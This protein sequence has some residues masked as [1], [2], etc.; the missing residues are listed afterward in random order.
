MA[1]QGPGE[2]VLRL[3]GSVDDVTSPSFMDDADRLFAAGSITRFV[4]DFSQTE[5]LDS[6]GL[7]LLVAI[8]T[9]A[10]SNGAVVELRAMP[11][12]VRKLVRRAGLER[13]FDIAG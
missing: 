11:D 8:H 9:K 6:S 13:M 12:R 1:E 5:F 2:V 7:G 10:Q 4:V 3:A